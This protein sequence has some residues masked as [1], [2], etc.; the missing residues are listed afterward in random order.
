MNIQFFRAF[1]LLALIV[2]SLPTCTTGGRS[3]AHGEGGELYLPSANALD[4]VDQAVARA[5]EN[6]RL[7][8][9]VLGANWCHDSRALAARLQQEPLASLVDQHYET[10]FVDVGFVDKGTDVVNHFGVPGYY[11]TPT[12]LI[13]D[14]GTGQ[15]VNAYDRHRWGLAD[16]ISME[17]TVAYFERMASGERTGPGGRDSSEYARLESE[18]NAFEH[19]MAQRVREGY[20]V[21]S[22]LLKAYEEGE[23]PD[24]FMLLWEEVSHFRMTLAEDIEALRNGVRDRVASGEIGVE[25][26]FPAYPPFSWEKPPA[27]EYP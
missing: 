3:N 21:L 7:A 17:D 26:A 18:I 15:L 1:V 12:V 10:V 16:S 20:A 25:L 11:A 9:I 27:A 5:M 13:V 24:D 14:P 2:F 8:L 4:D 22:P 23:E 19:K 6:G